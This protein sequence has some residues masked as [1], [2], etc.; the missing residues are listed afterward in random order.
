[1]E[2]KRRQFRVIFAN[3]EAKAFGSF[4]FESFRM[5][6]VFEIFLKFFASFSLLMATYLRIVF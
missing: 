4:R 6:C 5:V 3:K 2:A 1:M